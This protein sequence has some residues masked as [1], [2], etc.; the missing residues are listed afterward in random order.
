MGHS[1]CDFTTMPR[2]FSLNIFADAVLSACF[3]TGQR[4]SP[5]RTSVTRKRSK[6]EATDPTSHYIPRDL[7]P[8]RRHP[9]TE[10]T[11]SSL[12][13]PVLMPVT[14]S[15]MPFSL[16][17]SVFRLIRDDS[18]AYMDHT[19]YLIFM[20]NSVQPCP[21]RNSVSSFGVRVAIIGFLGGPSRH[22]HS[23]S[24]KGSSYW[25]TSS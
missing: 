7:N 19:F 23:S 13:H 25:L 17:Y 3:M 24:L 16:L 10:D 8:R 20:Q 6:Q 21:Q 15:C 5:A 12:V 14:Y 9:L 4:L 22:F 1:P 2:V 11:R 18:I